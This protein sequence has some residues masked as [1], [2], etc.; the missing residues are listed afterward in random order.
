MLYYIDNFNCLRQQP[1]NWFPGESE[2]ENM[3]F[4]KDK[5]VENENNSTIF[6][7]KMLFIKNQ[8]ATSNKKR[9]D[10]LALDGQGNSVIIELKRDKGRLGVETQALQYLAEFSQ[11]KGQNFIDRFSRHCESLT[12]KIDSF[13][14]NDFKKEI[15]RASC[16]ERV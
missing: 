2:L 12:D 15:G 5:D 11:Y 3:I 13:Y 9:A 1:S 10:I 16:R 4:T 8:A 6:F 7:E 14:G